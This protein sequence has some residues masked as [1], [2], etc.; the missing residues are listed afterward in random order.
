MRW[1]FVS[2]SSDKAFSGIIYNDSKEIGGDII[3]KIEP[4][5]LNGLEKFQPRHLAGFAVLRYGSG[6]K[7][8]WGRAKAYMAVAIRDDIRSVVKRGADKIGA[9]R[10]C[11]EY[12]NIQY[13]LLLLPVWISTYR[14]GK[15]YYGFFINGQ[16]GE[17]AGKSP[18]SA[19]KVFIIYCAFGNPQLCIFYC[20]IKNKQV[21]KRSE[22][23][24]C[25]AAR[26]M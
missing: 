14:F 6:L 10:I 25:I 17:I 3:R 11:P 5:K 8:A 18:K 2:G 15:K 19:L 26:L 9:I 7:S 16:T 24:G 22:K 13:R 20:C 4:Y 21:I 12:S 23:G 1:R